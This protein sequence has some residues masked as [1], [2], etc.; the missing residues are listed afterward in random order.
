MQVILQALPMEHMQLLYLG[1]GKF[2]QNV[3]ALCDAAVCF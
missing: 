2:S 3:T 1:T